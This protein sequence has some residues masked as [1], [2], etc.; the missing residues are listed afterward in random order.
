MKTP[1]LSIA[2]LV[3]CGQEPPAREIDGT[4]ALRYAEAQLGFGPRIPGSEGH[5]RMAAWLDSLLRTRADSVVPQRWTHVTRQG[6]SLPLVNLLARFNLSAPSRILFL[7]HWDTR[8]RADGPA[9]TDTLAPVMGANDGASGVA[10]L[11]AMADALKAAAPAIGVDLLF[12]DGEDYGDFNAD[13]DVLLGSRYYAANQ[14]PGPKPRFAILLDMVGDRDLRIAPEY[15]SQT[16]APEVVELV[17]DMARRM[18]YGNVFVPDNGPMLTDDHVPLQQ[19]G[20]R[21]INVIDFDY[22]PGNRWHHTPDDTLD[23]LSGES[24]AIV[25]NVMMGVVRGAR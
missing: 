23:K 2:F 5:R 22:G 20:L 17:W 25:G 4:A 14:P 13:V 15:Y 3:A 10:V 16:A 18:G 24:L 9:S 11:L 8:P 19:A 12:V 6:D 1:L 21:A 7:A